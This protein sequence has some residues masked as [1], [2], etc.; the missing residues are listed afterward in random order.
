MKGVVEIS[1]DRVLVSRVKH[2]GRS[3]LT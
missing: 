1:I 2:V 3:P